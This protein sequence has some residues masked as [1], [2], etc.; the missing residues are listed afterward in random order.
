[1]TLNVRNRMAVT[2]NPFQGDYKKVL[3]VCS[4]GLLRSPTAAF[5]LSNPPFNFNTRSVGITTEFALIPLDEALLFWSQEIVCME[6]WQKE[7]IETLLREANLKRPV[8]NLSIDDRHS[9]RDPELMR[10][11]REQYVLL[12]GLPNE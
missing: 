9:Y 10:L 4:A 1:M 5:V 6:N 11:V 3:C 7:R 2:T 12:K 8:I